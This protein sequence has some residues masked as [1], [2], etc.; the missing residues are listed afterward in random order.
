MQYHVQAAHPGATEFFALRPFPCPK[1][2]PPP[3]KHQV[4][5]LSLK[6]RQSTSYPPP[7]TLSRY[8]EP[9][10][11]SLPLDSLPVHHPE[12]LSLAPCR[13][14]CTQLTPASSQHPACLHPLPPVATTPQAR[15]SRW[16][17]SRPPP[18]SSCLSAM[19]VPERCVGFHDAAPLSR[20]R[21]RSPSFP[22]R[23]SRIPRDVE[24][25]LATHAI[26]SD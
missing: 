1:S 16:L 7:A 9:P 10:I 5:Q 21:R 22:L 20:Y 13:P 23:P 6:V 2:S 17:S 15:P 4:D 18:S 11:S 19:V 3:S 26:N 25:S 24:R 8:L 14:L 12:R